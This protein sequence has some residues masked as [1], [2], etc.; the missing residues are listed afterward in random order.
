MNE[1][2]AGRAIAAVGDVAD[3]NCWSGIPFH[4]W[5]AAARN[6]VASRPC[7]LDLQA[8]AWR[9]RI[10]NALQVARGRGWGGYQYSA[11]FLEA[12]ERQIPR[13]YLGGEI[14]SF[15]QHFPRAS[16]MAR[17]GGRLLHYV[18]ATFASFNTPGGFAEL[19]PKQIKS[20]ALELERE[21]YAASRQIVTMA[22][23]TALSVIE[24]CGGS[25]KKVTTI[26]PGANVELPSGHQFRADEGAPGQERPLV[27][28]FVGKDWRRKGLPFLLQ[29]R[30]ALERMGLSVIVRAA[31]Q[32]PAE[33]SNERGLEHVGFIDKAHEPNRFLDF[34]E[35][36]DL[37]C[38]FSEREPL[39][40]STLEF[41]RA[42]VPVTGF[43]VDGL[44]DTI[45]P[46]AGFRFAS[47]SSA[48][49]VAEVLRVALADP[50]AWA[51]V[52][53]GAQAW[54]PQVTWERCA[55]EWVELL[56]TGSVANPA[57]P[58]LPRQAPL[59]K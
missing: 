55:A 28:G 11:S 27:L 58:W 4:F 59:T 25:P 54:S 26:L 38:L 46:D 20:E 50:A 21:N 15:H 48:E 39:G 43:T 7:R 37:G 5:Q 22:R 14:I 36:C 42:G 17:H 35:G 44:A 51:R 2:V 47:G 23:W 31:G 32:R 29:V 9:R 6:G 19:L 8:L 57:R 53:Q 40:I 49:E 45:P 10:W 12:A 34:L 16:T 18:D 33:L 3:I 13:G 30:S 1:P 41:L 56:A 24:E 52:R